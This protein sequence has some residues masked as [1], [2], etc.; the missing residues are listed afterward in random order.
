ML[1]AMRLA[2]VQCVAWRTPSPQATG[3]LITLF[4]CASMEPEN[5]GEHYTEQL[6]L[7]SGIGTCYSKP[8]CS[9]HRTAHIMACLKY[10]HIFL[11]TV[12]I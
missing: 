9:L 4:S 11:P 2:P 3:T 10:G 6:F 5:A 1:G 12:T 8:A 7:L